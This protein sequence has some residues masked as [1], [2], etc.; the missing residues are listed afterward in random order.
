MAVPHPSVAWRANSSFP[1][2]DPS[3]WRSL[4]PKPFRR[5]ASPFAK[6]KTSKLAQFK[7]WMAKDWNP[8]TFFIIIFLLIGSMSINSI[9]L[10][11]GFETFIRQSDVR[12]GLLREVV[13]KL[14]KGEEVD[15]EKVLGTG[16]PEK[17]M[18]WEQVLNEL[19]K[20]DVARSQ[21]K[22]QAEPASSPKV[23]PTP[24]PEPT[25]TIATTI[26]PVEAATSRDFF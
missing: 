5:T 9:A 4:V 24:K 20:E 17:E 11:K 22:K 19:E 18:E 12:I 14:Q 7:A 26:E 6:K 8:A 21:K 3:F 25:K 2:A 15:V 10:K 13:E 16:V 23:E 1:I